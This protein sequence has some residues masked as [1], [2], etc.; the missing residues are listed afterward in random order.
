[1]PWQTSEYYET[2]AATLRPEAFERLHLNNWT[3]SVG[4]FI[5]IEWWYANRNSTI[6]PP[7]QYTTN[8]APGQVDNYPIVLGVD[9]AVSSDCCAVSAVS[10]NPNNPND[11]W[12]RFYNIW[13]PP[14]GG[15]MDL[16]LVEQYLKEICA[17]YNVVQIAYDAYQLHKLMTDLSQQGVAWC[18]SFSQGADRA[19]ADKQLYDLIRDRRCPHDVGR[20]FDDQ[21]RNAAAKATTDTDTKLRLVKKSQESKIDVIVATSMAVAECLRLNLE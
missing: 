6:R 5:P 15:T 12:V 11:P 13:I 8:L 7:K 20:D 10:R 2:Q 19:I 14:K 9:A 17:K 4:S 21:L 16:G 1:M 18:K 3:S